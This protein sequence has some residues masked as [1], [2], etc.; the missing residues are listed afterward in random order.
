L[1][2]ADYRPALTPPSSPREVLVA[3]SPITGQIFPSPAV[4]K[5]IQCFPFSL[6]P[7][8][9]NE[10]RLELTPRFFFSCLLAASAPHKI[11]K[12]S[13]FRMLSRDSISQT[14]KRV[15]LCLFLPPFLVRKFS[16]VSF[17]FDHTGARKDFSFYFI[18]WRGG[19]APLLK[20]VFSLPHLPAPRRTSFPFFF[21]HQ[22][23]WVY[24]V[25]KQNFSSLSSSLR[26]GYKRDPL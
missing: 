12:L 1:S 22:R 2:R 13:P 8:F 20:I 10:N 9:K 7:L 16:F 5:F 11:S 3:P 15:T 17:F 25:K 18:R 24:F 6:P 26:H 21:W 4:A 23:N 14:P 19:A